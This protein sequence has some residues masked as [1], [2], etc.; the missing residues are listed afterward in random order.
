LY[1]LSAANVWTR[2][3]KNKL[4]YAY[5]GAAIEKDREYIHFPAGKY[6]HLI[7]DVYTM[8]EQ[9]VR[10]D[11]PVMYCRC[12]T[13]YVHGKMHRL[14]LRTDK[15]FIP[16]G[17]YCPLCKRTVMDSWGDKQ[18]FKPLDPIEKESA[19]EGSGGS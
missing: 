9:T 12:N 2:N 14:Y 19:A 11:Q 17:W 10:K 15:K 6:I 8:Q 7:S 16:S 13:S 18:Q 5:P 4:V 3:Q 1:T